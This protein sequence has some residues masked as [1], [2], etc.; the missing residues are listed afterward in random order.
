MKNV[1]AFGNLTGQE[2]NN[3]FLTHTGKW[4]GFQCHSVNKNKNE[5]T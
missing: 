2:Q 4:L 3:N 1:S 5:I